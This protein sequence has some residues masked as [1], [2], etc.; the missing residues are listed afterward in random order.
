MVIEIVT[1]RLA[2]GTDEAA[3]LTADQ[4]VQTEFFYLQPGLVRRTTA[5]GAD[6]DWLVLVFWD[7]RQDAESAGEASKDH[8]AVQ[9]FMSLIDGSTYRVERFEALEG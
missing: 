7:R 6:G 4:R 3:F 1:F 2:D 5:R 9:A 8:P